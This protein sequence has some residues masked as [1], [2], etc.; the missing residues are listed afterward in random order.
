[1]VG[2]NGS[3]VLIILSMVASSVVAV[4]ESYEGGI[5]NFSNWITDSNL[6][7]VGAPVA[8]PV[9][10]EGPSEG[11]TPAFIASFVTV[12]TPTSLRGSASTGAESTGSS[13]QH[14]G[15][16]SRQRRRVVTSI[17][18][19]TIGA[20]ALKNLY[21][22]VTEVTTNIIIENTDLTSLAGWFPN[23][24][25]VTNNIQINNN[26]ALTTMDASF[27]KLEV[28]T[29]QL[30]IHG[31]GALVELGSA[32]PFPGGAGLV[33]RYVSIYNNPVLLSLGSALSG[34]VTITGYCSVYSNAS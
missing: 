5:G 33:T 21:D 26:A 25:L 18:L 1:M 11:P 7:N 15:Q 10:S 28:L 2:R 20:A 22:D 17:I 4:P 24:V 34:L 29:G 9:P 23:L 19:P 16:L 14:R 31:N 30:D 8:A 12:K 6:S 13:S 27:Q 32:L 3:A